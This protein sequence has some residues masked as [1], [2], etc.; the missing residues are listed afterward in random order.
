MGLTAVIRRHLSCVVLLG[1][2]RIAWPTERLPIRDQLAAPQTANH[3]VAMVCSAVEH[4]AELPRL[5]AELNTCRLPQSGMA[6]QLQTLSSQRAAKQFF[7]FSFQVLTCVLTRIFWAC[8]PL[9]S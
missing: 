9:I 4:C 7:K 5:N 3:A 2:A 8:I 1:I 6:E